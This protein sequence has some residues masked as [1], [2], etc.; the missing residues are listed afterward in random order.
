MT[1]DEVIR[2]RTLLRTATYTAKNSDGTSV[3]LISPLYVFGSNNF[4]IITDIYDGSF[5]WDDANERILF[6]QYNSKTDMNAPAPAMSV[7]NRPAAPVLISIMPYNEIITMR[8]ILTE[9][10][11]NNLCDKGLGVATLPADQKAAIYK[12]FFTDL[13][14]ETVIKQKRKLNYVSQHLKTDDEKANSFDDNDEYRKT[15]NPIPLY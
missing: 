10:S 5:I 9:E 11:F 14:M 3:T 13:D 6:F 2:N 1:K 15:V 8:C 12:K 7:G 4:N